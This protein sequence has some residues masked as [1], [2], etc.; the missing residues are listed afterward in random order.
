MECVFT[1]LYVQWL[2]GTYLTKLSVSVLFAVY[3][4]YYFLQVKEPT[5]CN[6][7][8]VNENTQTPAFVKTGFKAT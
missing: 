6:K 8:F 5:W 3:E 7:I 1:V 4:F 2:S